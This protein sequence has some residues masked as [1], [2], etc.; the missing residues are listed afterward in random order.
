VAPLDGGDNSKMN[1][2]GQGPELIERALPY[3]FDAK[4]CFALGEDGVRCTIIIPISTSN[5]SS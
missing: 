5:I 4:T 2:G 3:Q 1:G